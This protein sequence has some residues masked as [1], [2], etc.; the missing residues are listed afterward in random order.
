MK[1]FRVLVVD[2]EP[3]VCSVLQDELGELGYLCSS[4]FTGD[5]AL[6]KLKTSKYNAVLLDIRLPGMSGMEVLREIWLNHMGVATIM[7]TAVS[8][9]DTAIE[10]MRYG[11]TDYI[12][13]PFSLDR[14]DASLRNAL[15]AEEKSAN[16]KS[17]NSIAE[18]VEVLLDPFDAFSSV[19]TDRTVNIARLLGIAEPEIQGWVESR[20]KSRLQGKEVLRTPADTN[21]SKEL[22]W[23]EIEQFSSRFGG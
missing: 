22:V 9:T 4:V 5:D 16:R 13:K 3:T 2:D 12:V 18:G 8:E 6:T 21:E 23:R 7:I 11:A 1:Q 20:T 17:M 19:I 15:S 10:A 14:I